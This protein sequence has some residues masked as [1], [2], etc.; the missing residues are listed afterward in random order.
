MPK[1]IKVHVGSR[2]VLATDEIIILKSLI[3]YTEIFLKTGETIVVSVT[4]GILQERLRD[5]K[6]FIRPNRQTVVNLRY[7]QSYNN[8]SLTISNQKIQISRRRKC[9]VFRMLIHRP[10]LA[11]SPNFI[12]K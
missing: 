2:T 12:A 10:F 7:L 1:R 5:D 4:L 6:L 11:S 9:S 8:T 3:N